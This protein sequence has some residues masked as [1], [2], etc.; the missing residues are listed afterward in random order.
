MSDN[1]QTANASVLTG[2]VVSDKMDKSI[3]VLIER[4]VRHPL[5][6][7]QLRR[8]TK[9]KAHDENNVCQQGDL[10]R[11]KETRPISKTKSWTLVEV[12]EKVEK[13]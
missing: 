9:I 5:Y 12:V 7:K 13:I 3:T 10:V 2:R 1:N 4:L 6:G 11:I 8:S